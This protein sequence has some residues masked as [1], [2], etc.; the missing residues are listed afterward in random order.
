MLQGDETEKAGLHTARP[1]S[2]PENHAGTEAGDDLIALGPDIVVAGELT[3]V[4]SAEWVVRIKNFIV[5]DIG[6]LVAFIDRF[7][8]S[9]PNDRYV[10]INALG[11]GGV[12]RMRLR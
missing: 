4:G 6:T 3:T 10:L 1:Q 8:A 2:S 11:D 7:G 12:L 9:P 5:G